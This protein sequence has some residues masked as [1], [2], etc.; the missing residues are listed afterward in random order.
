MEFL[1][2]FEQF[3]ITDPESFEPALPA[4]LNQTYYEELERRFKEAKELEK[5]EQEAIER[6]AA[7]FIQDPMTPDE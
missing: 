4:G 6:V 7:G 1:K 3:I 5:E 2:T